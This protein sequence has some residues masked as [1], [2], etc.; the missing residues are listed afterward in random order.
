MLRRAAVL[1][2][3]FLIGTTAALAQPA[4][5]AGALLRSAPVRAALDA[6][7]ANEPATLDEQVR[8]CEIPAPPFKEAARAKAYAEMLRAAGLQDVEIDA[9]GN[10]MGLWRGTGAP[11]RPV[12]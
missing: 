1:F 12:G 2:A 6:V 3:C 5:A 7:R 11:G 10:A 9:E 4:V 8:L